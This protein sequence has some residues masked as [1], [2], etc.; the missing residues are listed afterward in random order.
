[1]SV[2]DNPLMP[3]AIG[4]SRAPHSGSPLTSDR[5]L[6]KMAFAARLRGLIATLR[7][8]DLTSVAPAPVFRA[9]DGI[10]VAAE[11]TSDAAL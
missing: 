10:P 11:G 2:P 9:V 6:E 8:L 7:E 5:H 1:M 3:A 4:A